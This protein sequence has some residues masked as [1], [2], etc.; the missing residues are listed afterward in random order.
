MVYFGLF[1]RSLEAV[2]CSANPWKFWPRS[3]F[4]G[5]LDHLL[6]SPIFL[7]WDP[8]IRGI[9]ILCRGTTDS[10]SLA[11]PLSPTNGAEGVNVNEKVK[12][13]EAWIV[14]G[15]KKEWLH[16]MKHKCSWREGSMMNCVFSLLKY[17][18]TLLMFKHSDLVPH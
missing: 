13:P 10:R 11:I 15:R 9:C 12:S 4:F 8:R 2:D 14:T 1:S 17:G 18:V 6:S 3:K 5:S 7:N 16:M